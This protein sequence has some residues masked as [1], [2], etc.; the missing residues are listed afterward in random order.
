[1]CMIEAYETSSNGVSMRTLCKKCESDDVIKNGKARKL[2]RYRCKECSYSFVLGDRRE[3]TPQAVKALAILLYGMSRSSYSFLAKLFK[4]S[5]TAVY[6]WI[7]NYAESIGEAVV[8]KGD[9][10]IEFD[11]MWH[12]VGSKKQTLALESSG[13]S[14]AENH[15]LGYRQS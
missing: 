9:Y 5:P 8:N 15:C 11:E 14:H 7:R 1:M 13:P 10:D 3:R 2:Q 4:V 6:N 12:F